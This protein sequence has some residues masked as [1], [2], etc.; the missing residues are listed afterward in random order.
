MSPIA[1]IFAM[2]GDAKVALD[3]HAAVPVVVGAE[4]FGRRR[5]L[6]AGGPETVRGE[7]QLLVPVDIAV[8]DIV[9]RRAQA[10]FDAKLA[11][12]TVRRLADSFV[13]E[14]RQ[15]ALARFDQDDARAM[16]R[17]AAEVA[18]HR[19]AG[20]L[21]DRAGHFDPGR[22]AADDDEGQQRLAA[23]GVGLG[24]G[25]LERQQHLAADRERVLDRLEARR[26]GAQSSRPK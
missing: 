10:D 14:S 9:D 3:E 4:P 13:R 18:R 17:D 24:L 16:R 22:T 26:V 5:R 8:A 2:P 20:E 7:D 12:A 15:Q 19:S 21:G 6:D 25:A 23:L 1:K 11:R